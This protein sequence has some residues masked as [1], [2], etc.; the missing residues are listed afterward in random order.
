[1]NKATVPAILLLGSILGISSAEAALVQHFDKT[2]SVLEAADSPCIFF[3]LTG[4]T[5]ANPAVPS[6]VWFGI[7]K[8]QGNA[9]EMY[10]LLLSARLSG[11]SLARVLTNGDVVC[12]VAK[13]F[14]LDL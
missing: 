2:I 3:Q 12:G 14:T 11:T 7:D 5:E 10:A 8:N 4:V 9:K 6:G 13:A 1:M